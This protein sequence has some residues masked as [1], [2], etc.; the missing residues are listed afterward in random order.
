[1]I[2][3]IFEKAC[4]DYQDIIDQCVERE[5]PAATA[6]G[7]ILLMILDELRKIKDGPDERIVSEQNE[8][9]RLTREGWQLFRRNDGR[10]VARRPE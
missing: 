10:Y 4:S 7:I 5:D 1:M 8:V 6:Q 2:D 9:I 3:K